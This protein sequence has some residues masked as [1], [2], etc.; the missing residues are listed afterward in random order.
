MYI[1]EKVQSNTKCTEKFV[2][3]G[4]K[5]QS[6]QLIISFQ[7]TLEEINF[8]NYILHVID[9]SNPEWEIQKEMRRVWLI[10]IIKLF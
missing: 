7:T 6:T 8:S 2:K 10:Y 9:I 3:F 1:C 5:P 4:K